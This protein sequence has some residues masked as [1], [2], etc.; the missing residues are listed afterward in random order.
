MLVI[1]FG[2][3]CSP[4][5][6]EFV[7]NFNA[8][9]FLIVDEYLNCKNTLQ[10]ATDTFKSAIGFH[11]AAGFVMANWMSNSEE[12][13]DSIPHSH[14]TTGKCWIF[15]QKI[16]WEFW[17]CSESLKTIFSNF[18]FFW[19]NCFLVLTFIK[20]SV[21]WDEEISEDIMKNWRG[22]CGVV[23]YIE[24]FRISRYYF[25]LEEEI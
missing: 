1:I 22:W 6:A 7:K 5:I 10:E 8:N 18:D 14:I 23:K 25:Q 2:C 4:S 11:K 20:D 19:S 21:G 15:T 12:V 24:H 9:L 17:D 16:L 3:V 13:V